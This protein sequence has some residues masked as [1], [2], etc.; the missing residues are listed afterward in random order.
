MKIGLAESALSLLGS[1]FSPC[2]LDFSK[3]TSQTQQKTV[4]DVYIG[5]LE[6]L[7]VLKRLLLP[8]HSSRGLKVRGRFVE[9]YPSPIGLFLEGPA[10]SFQ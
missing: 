1:A 7:F 2:R 5:G 8:G 9:A 6:E 4:G 10:V 3:S